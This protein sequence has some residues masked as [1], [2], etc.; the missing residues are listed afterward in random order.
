MH[1]AHLAFLHLS[2]VLYIPTFLCT[3]KLK[4]VF[5]D[6]EFMEHVEHNICCLMSLCWVY[7]NNTVIYRYIDHK[8]DILTTL[9][10]QNHYALVLTFI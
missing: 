10:R 2:P 9:K 7:I 3:S 8:L 6:T 1:I 4:F 5:F